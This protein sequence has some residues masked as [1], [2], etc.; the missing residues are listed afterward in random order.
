MSSAGDK[1]RP[2]NAEKVCHTAPT[3]REK[4]VKE[5]NEIK[6]VQ[7][8]NSTVLKFLNQ[9]TSK[10]SLSFCI[11]KLSFFISFANF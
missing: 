1:K 2:L 8:D 5:H 9:M 3:N 11:H 6:R 4:Y 7:R 10:S